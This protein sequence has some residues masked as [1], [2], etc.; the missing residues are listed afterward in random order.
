MT[1]R[2][3]EYLNALQENLNFLTN[4]LW[5]NEENFIFSLFMRY[6]FLKFMEF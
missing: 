5:L 1:A 6:D 3:I 2:K 4:F